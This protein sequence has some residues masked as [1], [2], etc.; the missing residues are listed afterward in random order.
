MRAMCGGP[1]KRIAQSKTDINN[2]RQRKRRT[3]MKLNSKNN[4]K[5]GAFTLIEMIGVLAVI[6]ILAAVLIPRV[7]EAIN[8]SR[9]NN[10]AMSTQA[11]K[12]ALIDH[13]AKYG[14]LYV[15]GSTNPPA[16]LTAAQ[17][18]QFDLVLMKEQLMDKAFN[19]KISLANDTL[20]T[21]TRVSLLSL[22]G[23]TVGTTAVDATSATFDL[24]GTGGAVSDI[25]GSYTAVA[26]LHNVAAL[27][28]WELSN[29]IDGTGVSGTAGN[30]SETDSTTADLRGRVKYAAAAGTP[31]VTDVYIYL[32]HR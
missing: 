18:L 6:A 12:T 13:Y 7:F 15:D 21:S 32:T 22:A 24:D 5:A 3:D 2:N 17:A 16:A 31:P 4:R 10:A 11:A 19:T 26:I 14:A 20:G 25:S 29:R 27:D 9:I 23:A 28:A 8:S 1:V 30:L